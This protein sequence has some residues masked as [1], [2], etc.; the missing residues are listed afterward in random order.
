MLKKTVGVILFSFI[1]NLSASQ[2]GAINEKLIRPSLHNVIEVPVHTFLS[3]LATLCC[4]ERCCSYSIEISHRDTLADIRQRMKDGS[5]NS[6]ND[7]KRPIDLCYASK[8]GGS[9]TGVVEIEASKTLAQ[10]GLSYYLNPKNY[11]VYLYY[12]PSCCIRD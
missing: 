3:Q 6:L 10:Q 4:L 5:H 7:D 2:A 11:E 8:N 1:S 9:A 12:N